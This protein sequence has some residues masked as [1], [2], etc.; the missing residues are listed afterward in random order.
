MCR[1]LYEKNN[2]RFGGIVRDVT[3]TF[4]AWSYNFSEA[5]KQKLLGKQQQIAK[6]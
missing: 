2:W 1:L 6:Q 5:D 3:S 4:N